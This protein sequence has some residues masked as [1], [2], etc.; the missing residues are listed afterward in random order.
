MS[1][2]DFMD[3]AAVAQAAEVLAEL[4]AHVESLSAAVAVLQ[5]AQAGPSDEQGG[6]RGAG[7]KGEDPPSPWC[8]LRM[9]HV[10]KA[11]CLAELADW[12]RDVLFAWPEAQRAY[13]PCWARHWDVIEELSMLY[14]A[15]RTAYLWK[16]ATS[17]DVGDYLD[18]LLPAAI[19][20]A[21]VRLRP[22]AQGHHPDGARRDD[23]ELVDRTITELRLL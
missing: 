16:E 14:L 12:V 17:R 7:G 4:A 20:R 2:D 3:Q 15:W 5:A 1:N 23:A 6:G 13:A 11:E 21:V 9:S 18:R 10:E 8:W 22:C 19:A